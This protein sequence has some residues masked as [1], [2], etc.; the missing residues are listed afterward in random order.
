M[1]VQQITW[2]NEKSLSATI[3]ARIPHLLIAALLLVLLAA[4]INAQSLQPVREFSP[5]EVGEIS[6]VET[7][8]NELIT[9]EARFVQ[10]D[11]TGTFA[12]GTFYVDRPGKMRFDYDPPTPLL[13]VADG[14]WFIYVD[15]ELDEAT[16]LPISSTPANFLL[17]ETLSFGKDYTVIDIEV[18][19]GVTAIDI[20]E[21]ENPDLGS[22]KLVFE[23]KPYRLRQWV[24][25]DAQNQVTRVTLT[26][27][28][29]GIDLD[30]SLFIYAKAPQ[31][32]N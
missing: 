12:E 28:R 21:T 25:T 6:R 20:I 17:R 3:L 27:Q 11:P 1:S 15:R 29:T 9:L 2:A 10:T 19:N 32:N 22:V 14:F 7:Y 16:H 24:I 4:P 18:A 23:H 30:R 31:N 5:D 8:L 26:E 13:L